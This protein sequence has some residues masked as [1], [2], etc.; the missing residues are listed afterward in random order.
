ML[1]VSRKRYQALLDSTLES[2][3][4]RDCEGGRSITSSLWSVFSGP[5][6]GDC[7]S[8][9]EGES[10]R[11]IAVQIIERGLRAVHFLSV[12]KVV[13]LY[14]SMRRV[15]GAKIKPRPFVFSRLV[16]RDEIRTSEEHGG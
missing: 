3:T 7:S 6:S 5:I 9:C 12:L 8:T 4:S 10:G 13:R 11:G 16:L 1:K 14:V 15:M 2:V